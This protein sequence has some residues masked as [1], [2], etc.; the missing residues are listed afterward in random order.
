MDA[1]RKATSLEQGQARQ[2]ARDR[3]A[4]DR[5][6]LVNGV[7]SEHELT[8]E[9]ARRLADI[10][11]CRSCLPVDSCSSQVVGQTK[12][13]DDFVNELSKST[14]YTVEKTGLKRTVPNDQTWAF[15]FAV[16]LVLNNPIVSLSE[17]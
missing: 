6:E 12:V 1:Y 7:P 5:D 10:R 2:H 16:P 11:E 8:P 17:K 3:P 13:V 4:G 14:L 15:E 9:S